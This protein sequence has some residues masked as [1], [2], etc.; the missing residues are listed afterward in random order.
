MAKY[1]RYGIYMR[2]N[3]SREPWTAPICLYGPYSAMF[4]SR[5]HALNKRACSLKVPVISCFSQI[6]IRC[7]GSYSPNS[8]NCREN[9]YRTARCRCETMPIQVRL[10][11]ALSDRAE[12][13]CNKQSRLGRCANP[14]GMKNE[15]NVQMYNRA[16]S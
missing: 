16:C 7:I 4:C 14:D 12:S 3:R 10:N 2:H 5:S 8:R 9:S 15:S 11:R 6:W 13:S 1:P